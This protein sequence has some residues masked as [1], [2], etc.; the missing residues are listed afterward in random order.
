MKKL[1][2][3]QYGLDELVS[4]E[5][6]INSHKFYQMNRPQAD[7]SYTIT[8]ICE[9]G[10]IRLTP[11]G[12]IDFR[13]GGLI[14]NLDLP[15]KGACLHFEVPFND[16]TLEAQEKIIDSIVES[17]KESAETEGKEYLAKKWHDPAPTTWQ[18]A[19][20][21]TYDVEYIMWQ[22]YVNNYGDPILGDEVVRPDDE[23]WVEWLNEELR[24]VAQ[25][26]AEKGF[27][28]LEAEVEL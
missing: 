4:Y 20:C 16:L 22:D 13:Y 12:T 8:H 26:K 19:Y 28:Y 2:H 21:R 6:Y 7:G 17:L 1:K 14:P 24:Q 15:E 18:E 10:A 3:L 27:R 5:E 11:T 25:K 9:C 23:E